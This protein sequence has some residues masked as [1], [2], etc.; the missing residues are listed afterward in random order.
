MLVAFTRPLEIWTSRLKATFM[1]LGTA[2]LAAVVHM[3]TFDAVL[4]SNSK[5]IDS[6]LS[7]AVVMVAARLCT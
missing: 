7:D 3:C 2:R 1:T 6:S 5:A 4:A